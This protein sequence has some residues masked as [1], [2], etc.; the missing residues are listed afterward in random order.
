MLI[1]SKASH[2]GRILLRRKHETFRQYILRVRDEGL[3]RDE[4][5]KEGVQVYL[6][7]YESVRFGGME[8]TESEFIATMKLVYYLLTEMKPLE[9][10][11]S[12]ESISS[13]SFSIESKSIESF[14]D[15]AFPSL[16]RDQFLEQTTSG[17][18]VLKQMESLLSSPR[19]SVETTYATS[20][21]DHGSILEDTIDP[22]RDQRMQG[23]RLGEREGSVIYYDI[24]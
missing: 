8:L 18:D 15:T 6:N 1:M 21:I 7:T 13:N 17:A 14:V 12:V 10:V 5:A 2:F 11:E 4:V 24:D 20:M 9:T 22:E 19:K 16:S 3:W 23:E